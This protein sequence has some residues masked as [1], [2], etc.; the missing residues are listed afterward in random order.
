MPNNLEVFNPTISSTNDL[1]QLL[2]NGDQL[3]FDHQG[4]E[5]TLILNPATNNI[6]L[7]S[8]QTLVDNDCQFNSY[9]GVDGFIELRNGSVLGHDVGEAMYLGVDD[10]GNFKVY[11]ASHELARGDKQLVLAGADRSA[12]M[13]NWTF[14]RP[15]TETPTTP[16]K[17]AATTPLEIY[18]LNQLPPG[19]YTVQDGQATDQNGKQFYVGYIPPTASY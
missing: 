11:D 10:S 8:G 19:Q 12:E 17:T 6:E 16:S 9:F 18:R 7:W 14:Y 3:T 5:F 1:T 4:T 2:Q 15:A 13:S